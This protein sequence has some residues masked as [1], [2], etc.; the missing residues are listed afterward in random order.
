[1]SCYNEQDMVERAVKSILD[2]T[3]TNFEFIIIND[4]SEDETANIL[5]SLAR[6]DHRIFLIN[7][8]RKGG[9]PLRLNEGIRMAQGKYIARMDA[10][11]YSFSTRLYDQQLYLEEHENIDVLGSSVKLVN[12]ET[13]K[14]LGVLNM[15]TNHDDIVR[16]VFRKT[17]VIHPSVMVRK[18]V[19]ES[20]GIYDETLSWAEDSDL[21]LR[22]YDKVRFHN[23]PKALLSYSVKQK[24][25]FKIVRGNLFVKYI[26]LRRRKLL[27]THGHLLVRDILLL[28]Y[29]KFTNL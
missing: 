15:P 28:L 8:S 25:S 9:L 3:F 26:N 18:R 2:Q 5:K 11:D 4:G 21:W 6:V 20:C 1:M 23:L 7:H 12:K 19:F 27:L 10:D 17:L 16:R 13:G 29:K 24:I 22:I 14:Y